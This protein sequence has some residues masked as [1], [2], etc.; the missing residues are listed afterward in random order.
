MLPPHHDL[1]AEKEGNSLHSDP[2][3]ERVSLTYGVLVALEPE[4][5]VA[6]RLVRPQYKRTCLIDLSILA[7]LL[8]RGKL[9]IGSFDCHRE[10][11]STRIPGR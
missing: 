1:T 7:A 10:K 4:F 11:V 9:T 8:W 3:K 2:T 6:P 5:K